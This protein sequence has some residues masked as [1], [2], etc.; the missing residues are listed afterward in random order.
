MPAKDIYHDPVKKA[1]IKDGW[2]ITNDPLTIEYGK[3]D[4]FVDLG[5]KKLIAAQKREQKI[6]VEI[7]SFTGASQMND[8]EKAVG[9]YIVYQN[10][11]EETEVERR[12]YLAITQKTFQDIFSE[13]IGNLILRKNNLN[14]L[15]FQPK[16]EEIVQWID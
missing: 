1:L 2:T 16:T 10:I 12:L 13:P 7:K 3:K 14:L 8:L 15:I 4:L 6:A 9:Q 11:L 5:A